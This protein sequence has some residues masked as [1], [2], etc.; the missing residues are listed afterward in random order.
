MKF[1][2]VYNESEFYDK[3]KLIVMNYINLYAQFLKNFLKPKR[4]LKVI[5]DC[6][7]GTTGIVLKELFRKSKIKN[8]KSK[9][10]TIFINDRPNGYFPAHG[11]DP[12]SEK[13]TVQLAH[14]VKKQKADF[15][16]VFDSDGDRA[17][18][19]DNRGRRLDGD[20]VV[21][22]LIEELRPKKVVVDLNA[23][24]LI[25]KSKFKN[26]NAKYKTIIS[27]TGSFF[28]KAAM[29]KHKAEF[30]GERS[31]HYYF[32]EFFNAD[33][34]ILAAVFMINRISKMEK[35]EL[36]RYIDALPQYHR[37]AVNF[38][39]QGENKKRIIYAVQE[40]YKNVARKIS[41]LDG[42]TMEFGWGW[43]NVRPS[44]TED[45]LRLTIEA[46]D[47][48]VLSEWTRK[49]TTLVKLSFLQ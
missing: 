31:G 1:D 12:T 42:L 21:L 48:R 34:G 44:N 32:K 16:V 25:R 15:G 26:Q 22:L 24:W 47:K 5:F 38:P 19:V 7:D 3:G 45:I 40:K 17:V 2:K 28:I 39:V 4:R 6:S 9:I 23:G 13:A 29:Q 37:A 35:G 8:Q 27:K 11:P 10:D 14:A 30:A 43:F 33:S 46:R 20:Q 36:G 41:Q 18:F 49:L